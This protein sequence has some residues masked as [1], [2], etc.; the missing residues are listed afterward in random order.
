MV[1][2]TGKSSTKHSDGRGA[3]LERLAIKDLV[4]SAELGLGCRH[5]SAGL[6]RSQG[7]PTRKI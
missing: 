1:E 4:V 6:A 7:S 5:Q 3:G 2:R